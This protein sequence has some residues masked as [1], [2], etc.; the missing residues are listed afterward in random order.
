MLKEKDLFLVSDTH[1]LHDKVE[2][3]EPSRWRDFIEV[4]PLNMWDE[5]TAKGYSLDIAT[6]KKELNVEAWPK[7][8]I[9]FPTLGL[10]TKFFK[11]PVR[12]SDTL[13]A[14]KVS[15]AF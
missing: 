8:N 13:E 6:L 12:F 14:L 7:M 3:Y 2:Q 10:W 11:K 15:W 9:S 4:Q 1:F 5:F